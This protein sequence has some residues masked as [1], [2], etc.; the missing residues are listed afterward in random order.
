MALSHHFFTQ[1]KNNYRKPLSQLVL[2]SDFY[3]TWRVVV[4]TRIGIL[5][6]S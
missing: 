5:E 3:F 6:G 4:S 2:S 1:S